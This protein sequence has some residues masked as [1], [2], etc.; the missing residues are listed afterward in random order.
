LLFETR[1]PA[2]LTKEQRRMFGFIFGTLCLVGLVRV[3]ARGRYGGR[4]G[5][6]HHHGHHRGFGPRGA[7]N[8]LLGRL[9]TAPG[10]EKVITSAVDEF[11][12]RA[13]ESRREVHDTRRAIADALRGEHLDEARLGEVFVRHDAALEQV[14]RA[15]VDAARKVHEALDE[16]QRKILGDLV[17]NGF[18]GFG[19]YGHHRHGYCHGC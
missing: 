16:R 18:H 6:W 7:L 9:D 5:Y 11:I 8:G 17:E 14:R 2:G 19:H 4:F 12:G 15:G 10:Q 3:I 13:R 1:T